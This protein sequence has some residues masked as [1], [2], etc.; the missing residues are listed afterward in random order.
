[1]CNRHLTFILFKYYDLSADLFVRK[2]PRESDLE[3]T[4]LKMFRY[5]QMWK[6]EYNSGAMLQRFNIGNTVKT[7]KNV[8][9][10][11]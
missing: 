7:E 9:L 5:I 10:I 4:H 1:M 2:F 8:S 11:Y 3:S 6:D